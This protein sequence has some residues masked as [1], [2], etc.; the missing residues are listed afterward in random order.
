MA[1]G[2]MQ[3]D[4]DPTL[5]SIIY[6]EDTAWGTREALLGLTGRDPEPRVAGDLPEVTEHPSASLE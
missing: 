3:S 2:Q 1:N 6:S 4:F 5:I